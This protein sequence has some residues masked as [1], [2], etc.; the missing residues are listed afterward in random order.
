LVF[1]AGVLLGVPRVAQAMQETVGIQA[2][3]GQFALSFCLM[4]VLAP[5]KR[6]L[7]PKVVR[8]LFP[9]QYELET[10]VAALTRE[11]TQ[12]ANLSALLSFC[13]ECLPSLWRSE[14][15]VLYGRSDGVYVPI[16]AQGSAIPSVFSAHGA[17]SSALQTQA[18][19]L[20][21]ER[22]RRIA[23]TYLTPA[24]STVLE[25]LRVEVIVPLYRD[26][27]LAAFVCLGPKRSGD[28]YTATDFALLKT[29]SSVLGAE[30][31]RHNEETWHLQI[32]DM[33]GTLR[34]TMLEPSSMQ[35]PL[36]A[37]SVPE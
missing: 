21:V 18:A 28:I 14:S 16:F 29:V 2:G 6:V 26:K 12:R 11:L 3:Y 17:L 15:C 24:D 10:E 34:S 20:E 8:R 7:L 23:G 27:L 30:F 5:G 31:M 37:S 22:W 9:E 1:L 32:A 13:G 4:L 25:N 33:Y 36:A 19:P 35:L